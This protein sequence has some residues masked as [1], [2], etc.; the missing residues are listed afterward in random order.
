M[1]TVPHFT[2]FSF[3]AFKPLVI[4]A[5]LASL[6]GCSVTT[7]IDSN[8]PISSIRNIPNTSTT[9]PATSYT[10]GDSKGELYSC[11]TNF[12]QAPPLI[13]QKIAV[14][15]Q[16]LCFNGFAVL[17]S[18]VTKTPLWSAQ[19]LTNDRIM[20]A[21]GMTRMDN[22]H[23]ES[24]LPAEYRSHLKDYTQTGFDRGHLAPNGDMAD[25][26][27]QYDS[28]SL[29]NIA[30]QNPIN[31]QKTWV[32]I[33]SKTRSL[34]QQ[35]GQV[36]TVTGVA[37]LTPNVKKLKDNVLVPSH[38]FKALYLPKTNQAVAFISP[39]DNSQQVE[40]ISLSELQ[41]R[42]GVNAF[43]VVANA[44]KNQVANVE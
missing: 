19:N 24:R 25:S 29:A 31:N 9:T 21:K 11:R 5:A 35:Y 30:P 27:S 37:F 10:T 4:S 26:E 18:G 38:F 43:P 39:N 7:P 17:Y 12:Y 34:A 2:V 22:F 3:L 15:T 28:F 41:T 33:E 6:V 16:A 1:H 44:V 32:K 36:Y 23:E 42:T 20:A 8:K 40:K 14:K 13:S